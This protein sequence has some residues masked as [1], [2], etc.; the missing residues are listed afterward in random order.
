M[1]IPARFKLVADE[2]LV[3]SLDPGGEESP[4]PE[5]AQ[6]VLRNAR[7]P[8][9]FLRVVLAMWAKKLG[10]ESDLAA[11][12]GGNFAKFLAGPWQGLGR[13]LAGPWQGLDGSGG[14][15]RGWGG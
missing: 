14:W 11:V 7:G 13:A 3:P 5:I 2:A 6:S 10:G 15:C 1:S 8:L 12:A 9:R 4:V